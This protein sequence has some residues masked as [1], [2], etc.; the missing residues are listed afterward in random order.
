MHDAVVTNGRLAEGESVLVQGASSGVGLMA[1]LIAKLKGARV[2][3]GTSTNDERRAKLGDYGAD[4]ALD[5]QDDGWIETARE[6]A[7]GDGVNLVIDQLAGPL[8][9]GNLAACAVLGRIV[10]VGRLAGMKGELDF[11]MH[12]LKRISYIGVTFRTRTLDEVREISRRMR[13][14]IWDDVA[15]GRLNLP[16]DSTWKLD[17]VVEAQAHMAKNRHFGKILLAL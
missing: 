8:M 1:M 16:V 11:D 7:G 13:A 3:I 14:D 10:N 5:T 6:A 4:L 2:V 12:A 15:A 17:E 9:N